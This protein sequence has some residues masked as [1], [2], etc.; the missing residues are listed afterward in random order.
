M[1][2]RL[3]KDVVNPKTG[4]ICFE[5]NTIIAA[6]V[7][8]KLTEAGVADF[9]TIYTNDLDCGPFIAELLC[10]ATQVVRSLMR[11]LVDLSDDAPWGCQPRKLAENLFQNLFF[12]RAL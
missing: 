5:C 11:W 2:K 7:L 6:D 3:A 9:E 4:E 12:A 1:A 10:V 8:K